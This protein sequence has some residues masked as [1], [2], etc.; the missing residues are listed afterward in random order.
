MFADTKSLEFRATAT[1]A[2]NHV[3]YA[4]VNAEFDSP[5]VGQVDFNPAHAADYVVWTIQVLKT[6]DRAAP[7]TCCQLRARAI[8]RTAS[9][10]WV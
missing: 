3:Q 10:L 7:A 2:F 1:N 8:S 6:C 9:D 5:T 4:T